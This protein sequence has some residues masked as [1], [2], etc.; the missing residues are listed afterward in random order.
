M[1]SQPREDT[2]QPQAMIPASDMKRSELR[3]LALLAAT[4]ASST[5]DP[6]QRK[7]MNDAFATLIQAL[8]GVAKSDVQTYSDVR[9]RLNATGY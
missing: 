2:D 6:D 5:V 9:A 7:A 8:G 4:S 3:S 1:E